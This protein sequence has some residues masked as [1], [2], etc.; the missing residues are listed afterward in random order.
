MSTREGFANAETENV[1]LWLSN[2]RPM[3][4]QMRKLQRTW[5]DEPMRHGGEEGECLKTFAAAIRAYCVRVWH[6]LATPDGHELANVDWVEIAAH[7]VEP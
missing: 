4:D 7:W 6:T 2:Y 1:T 5:F 3:Y